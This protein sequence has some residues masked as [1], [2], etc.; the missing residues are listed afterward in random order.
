MGA[1]LRSVGMKK[2]PYFQLSCHPLIPSTPTLWGLNMPEYN[3]KWSQ[4]KSEEVNYWEFQHSINGI[5]W[6]WIQHV[7]PIQDCDD[8]F[9]AIITVS[10][11]TLLIR[12]R[13]IGDNG[14][15][16]WSNVKYLPEPVSPIALPLLL[17]FLIILRKVKKKWD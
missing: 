4:E 10:E 9:Q 13:A 3:A 17:F 8:C 14:T 11:Q 1:V 15:S 7:E 12:A 16:E 5:D 2:G 6:H